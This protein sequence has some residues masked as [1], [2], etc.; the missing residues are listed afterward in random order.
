M[1]DRVLAHQIS[2][3]ELMPPRLSRVYEWGRECIPSPITRI[4]ASHENGTRD[5][6]W[7]GLYNQSSR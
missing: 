7:T 6:T 3:D 1:H 4:E 5:C 2:V